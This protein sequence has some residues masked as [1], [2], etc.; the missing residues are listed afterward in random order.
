L[1]LFDFRNPK[2]R[3]LDD[4]LVLGAIAP[5]TVPAI[6]DSIPLLISWLIVCNTPGTHAKKL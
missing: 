1:S 4:S 2:G 5:E 6:I 3:Q